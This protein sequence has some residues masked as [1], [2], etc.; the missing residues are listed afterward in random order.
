VLVHDD[1]TRPDPAQA[2]L[3]LRRAR[4]VRISVDGNAHFC[5][6]L[7]TTRYPGR[8]GRPGAP[9][10]G[11][12]PLPLPLEVLPVKAV[13]VHEYHADP[14]IDDIPEPR[15]RVPSTSSSRSAA[16]GSA[17]PT[18]T[19]SRASGPTCRTRTCPT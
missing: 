15:S 17:A 1:G 4:S 2:E 16:P 18:C 11:P 3:V 14:S 6:G 8:R 9:S 12:S 5:R 10:R 7:L 13:R 19:S